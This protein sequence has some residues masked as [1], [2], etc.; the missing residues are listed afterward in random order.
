VG[1]FLTE[2]TPVPGPPSANDDSASTAYETSVLINVLANDLDD[3]TPD[4]LSIQSVG[5][6]DFGTAAIES[7]QIRYTPPAGFSGTATFSYTITDGSTTDAANVMVTVIAQPQT[8]TLWT[9]TF[10]GTDGSNRNLVN[11]N[12][13]PSFTDTLTAD[14]F[15]LTF[16]D[17]TFNGSV[18]MHSAAMAS[19]TY[20]S[21]NTNVDN[22]AQT[23][24]NGGWW[25]TEF[26]YTGGSQRISLSSIDLE[27]LWSNSSG[28]IQSGTGVRDIT[29]SAEYSLD[30]GVIWAPVAAPQTYDLTEPTGNDQ[31]QIRTFTPGSAIIVNHASHDLWLRIRAENA[32]I[33][34]GAYVNIK[35]VT[36][37][38]A[39]VPEA[40]PLWT[41][42]FTGAD[43]NNR[44]LVNTNVDPSLTDLLV[45]D[46][47][48]LTFG[49]ASFTGTVFMHSGT[50]ASG[51]YY[52]PR[53]NVDNPG[54]GSPQ[55]GGWWQAEFR[56]SG[57]TQTVSLTDV[58]LNVVWSNSSGSI[59]T[60]DATVRDI[61]LT[62][63]YSLNGGADWFDIAAPQ[64]YNLTVSG[65]NAAS[66][67]QD[68]TFTTASPITA[69]HAT[70]D[71]WV[72]V[73]AE[74]AN[75]TAG[76][77]VNIST[78]SFLGSVV[79]A[80]DYTLWAAQYPGADLSDPNADLDRDGLTN[81]QERI[82]GLDPTSGSTPT[83]IT[84]QLDPATRFFTYTRR[85]KSLTGIDYTYQW[86]DSLN[87][88]NDFTPASETASGE[89]P[90]E[91]VTVEV[92]AG[93]MGP[94]FFVQVVATPN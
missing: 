10:T 39:V 11:T 68:R 94:K 15:N 81:N 90:V 47:F 26:R 8:A 93:I 17:T 4:P 18:F 24:Q 60:G 33:A 83:P 80:A 69:N 35:S 27:M 37:Q 70:Q 52:S 67:P 25:Q 21:P 92:P 5:T 66:Q 32:G 23:T 55:N 1:S 13:D 3:G 19:G 91:S 64:T 44:N 14:D 16:Q 6:P 45:A 74:N 29:L 20:Y 34:T 38:G 30:G 61:T 2:G 79:P 84:L 51:T 85:L 59:Q 87:G 40:S 50:M 82:W 57:G 72:R 48:N 77:Y 22:P 9:T 62:A 88:W 65:Q 53:T 54:A 49:D 43:G 46:D 31:I 76:A 42:S 78:I 89:N 36:I 12:G 86:S 58:V 75:A 71:L 28:V 73:R 7:G 63:E 56:Y 41:T